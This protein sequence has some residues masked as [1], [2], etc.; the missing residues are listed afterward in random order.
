MFCVVCDH[1]IIRCAEVFLSV[2]VVGIFKLLIQTD[3]EEVALY[4]IFDATVLGVSVHYNQW[5]R[6]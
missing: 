4:C 1:T 2:V 3:L 5:A 6:E